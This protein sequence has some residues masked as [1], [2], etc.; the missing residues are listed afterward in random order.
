MDFLVEHYGEKGNFTKQDIHGR[1]L[2]SI[3]TT[4]VNDKFKVAGPRGRPK[5]DSINQS[6]EIFNNQKNENNEE[7][8]RGRPK[9]TI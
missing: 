1:F 2:K 5:I 9:K 3:S 4:L 7:R 8:K 6:Q